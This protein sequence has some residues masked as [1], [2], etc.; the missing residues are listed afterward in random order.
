MPRSTCRH[1]C[2][3]GWALLA[4]ARFRQ[5]RARAWAS[6]RWPVPTRF[7]QTRARRQTTASPA[8]PER[9]RTKGAKAAHQ[10]KKA[11]AKA[12]HQTK[13]RAVHQTKKARAVRQTKARERLQRAEWTALRRTP[14][15]KELR[16]TESVERPAEACC[17]SRALPA[18][19]SA[20]STARRHQDSASHL[21][22]RTCCLRCPGDPRAA[23]SKVG[24][25]YQTRLCSAA[26]PPTCRARSR[27]R[28]P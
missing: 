22:V 9:P 10:T 24:R 23:E 18:D 2:L 11:R 21:G 7:L 19:R 5:V 16:R 6:R 17:R 13:A 28:W 3:R 15:A 4:S 20:R 8:G 27:R 1:C 25:T 26:G 14:T 12:A